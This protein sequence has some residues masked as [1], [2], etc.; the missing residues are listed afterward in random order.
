MFFT[1]NVLT[2]D[3]GSLSGGSVWNIYNMKI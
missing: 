3:S 2:Y 1:E